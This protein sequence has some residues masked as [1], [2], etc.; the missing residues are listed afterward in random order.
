M[1]GYPVEDS[2]AASRS[3]S[4]DTRQKVDVSVYQPPVPKIPDI[5]LK[6]HKNNAFPPPQIPEV[7]TKPSTTF[8]LLTIIF[9]L[10]IIGGA[11]LYKFVL[12]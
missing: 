10:L 8:I 2:E 6:E 1:P 11:V 5:L 4:N 7:N 9:A 12:K 3:S